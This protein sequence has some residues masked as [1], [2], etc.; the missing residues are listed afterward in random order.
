MRCDGSF[1]PHDP[2]DMSNPNTVLD[3]AIRQLAAYNNRDT[4]AFCACFHDD[5]TVLDADG[6]V[7]LQGMTAFRERYGTMFATHRE[8]IGTVSAR[9]HLEPHVVE[10]EHWS[11]IHATTGEAIRGE[12][13][14]RYTARDGLIRWVQFFRAS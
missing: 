1:D 5:I 8:V 10:H 12:V 6:S 14:V 9:V 13:L 11:R 7:T 4:D 3:L 2:S